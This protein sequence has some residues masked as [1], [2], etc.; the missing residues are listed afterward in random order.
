MAA[1]VAFLR[2]INVGGRVVKMDALKR[3]FE[4]MAGVTKVETFIASGN[5]LFQ[6]R[7]AAGPLEKKIEQALERSLG[8]RVDTFLRTEAELSALVNGVKDD[9][10][11]KAVYVGFVRDRV[12]ADARRRFEALSTPDEQLS[13]D[14]REVYWRTRIGMGR[15]RITGAQIEKA[16]GGPTT[17]R[18]MTT[19]RKL[20]AKLT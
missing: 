17:F 11:W 14:G 15:S 16:L 4:A 13:V 12:A 6:A 7:G 2:A 18:S 8:Y 3:V 1:Y 9:S 19:V 10:D 5:V 20:A